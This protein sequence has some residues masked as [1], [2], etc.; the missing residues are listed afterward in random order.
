MVPG[1]S[2]KPLTLHPRKRPFFDILY[3]SDTGW[4]QTRVQK[5]WNQ[6][7][8]RSKRKEERLFRQNY[9]GSRVFSE[10][11]KNTRVPVCFWKLH[12]F[13]WHL[14]FSCGTRRHVKGSNCPRGACPQWASRNGTHG[15]PCL[16][17]KCMITRE[18]V[19]FFATNHV[20]SHW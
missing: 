16:R 4:Y 12:G 19:T 9:T 10:K 17:R 3:V 14:S 5:P 1:G 6:G 15:N 20:Y 7:F 18:P 13:P 8:C 11:Y 2:T